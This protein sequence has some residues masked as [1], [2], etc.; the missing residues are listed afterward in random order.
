MSRA[1][2]SSMYRKSLA[3]K[4]AQIVARRE[5]KVAK[6]LPIEQRI[7]SLRGCRVL[8]D[9][10]LALLYGVS[11]RRRAALRALARCQRAQF[12]NLPAHP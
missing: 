1:Y 4:P 7:L 3:I 8:V 5:E 10:D 6:P 11:R 12:S 2:D 9:A